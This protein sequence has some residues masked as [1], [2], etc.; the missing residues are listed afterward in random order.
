VER[1]IAGEQV[2]LGD[3][4]LEAVDFEGR[5]GD[6]TIAERTTRGGA[7]RGESAR[8]RD[9]LLKG[10]AEAPGN[11]FDIG[12]PRE[13]VPEPPKRGDGEQPKLRVQAS[14]PPD[15]TPML[16]T[17]DPDGFLSWVLPT[18]HEELA[19]LA[20]ATSRSAGRGTEA[21]VATFE[22][23]MQLP[24]SPQVE[25]PAARGIGSFVFKKV[26]R[27]VSAALFDRFMKQGGEQLARWM[28][29]SRNHALRAFTPDDYRLAMSRSLGESELRAIQHAGT[30]LL[31]IHGTNSLSHSGFHLL[32]PEFVRAMWD[33]YERR[34]L[35]FDHPTLSVDPGH[36]ARRLAELLPAGLDLQLDIVAHSRGGLV[37]RELAQR[38]NANGLDGK[39][40]VQSVTFVGTP[41]LGTPFCNSDHLASYVDAMTNLLSA[42]PD[43]GI[44]D[45]VDCVVGV[46]SHVAR[47]MYAGI[48][49]AMAMDPEGDYLK[50]LNAEPH[51]SDCEYRV[52]TSEFEPI[53]GSGWKRHLRDL[54]VDKVFADKPN[55]LVVPTDPDWEPDRVSERL[56][57]E[58]SSGVDHSTYWKNEQVLDALRGS[59]TVQNAVTPRVV[60]AAPEVRAEPLGAEPAPPASTTPDDAD[61]TT[62]A[63]EV[64]HG[65]LEHARYPVVVGHYRGSPLEGAEGYVDDRVRGVLSRR[66]LLGLYPEDEGQVFEFLGKSTKP[67]GVIVVGLGAPDDMSATKLVR[68]VTHAAL[69]RLVAV[70]DER[71][72][73]TDESE[74]GTDVGLSLVLL[75]TSRPG[76]LPVP[77]CVTAAVEGVQRAN[78][79]VG[80][81]YATSADSAR[82][83][84]LPQITRIE[85]LERD[86]DRAEI[87][88]RTLLKNEVQL[89]GSNVVPAK[90]LRRGEGARAA[91]A[92][93]DERSVAWR[94]LKIERKKSSDDTPASSDGTP[95]TLEY[96]LMGGYAGAPVAEHVVDPALLDPLLA[97]ASTRVD[98][99]EQVQN[100]LFELLFPREVKLALAAGGSFTMLL[101]DAVANYPW[102]MLASRDETPGS[103]RPEPLCVQGGFLRRLETKGDERRRGPGGKAAL[104][105]GNPPV[106]PTAASLPGACSEAVVVANSLLEHEYDV[107][108]LIFDVDG[109]PVVD[110]RPLARNPL[111][112]DGRHEHYWKTIVH[113]LFRREYRILHIAAHGHFDAEH[114][115]RSGALIGPDLFMSSAIVGSLPVIPDF[116][117]FNCCHLGRIDTVP[118]ARIAASVAKT[119]MEHGVRAVVAAGWAVDD[120]DAMTFATTLYDC[121]CGGAP[122]G[123]AV[124]EARRAIYPEDGPKSSTW[125]AY[126][127]YGDPGWRLAQRPERRGDGGDLQFESDAQRALA[128]LATAAG[129]VTTKQER[130]QARTKLAERLE[131]IVD[132]VRK[133]GW[134]SCNVLAALGRAQ[135]KLGELEGAI[136]SYREIVEWSSGGDY[137]VSVIEQ[138]AN[139]EF[140]LAHKRFRTAGVITPEVTKLFE[141]ADARLAALLSLEQT[142]ERLG[143]LGSYHKK[144]ATTLDGQERT[145]EMQMAY[146]AYLKAEEIDAVPY[147]SLNRLQLGALRNIPAPDDAV[148]VDD[149]E[150]R[151]GN[152]TR[153]HL[154]AAE[155]DYWRR[156][157]MVDAHL[158]RAIQNN[159][160][161]DRCAELAE[162]YASVFRERSTWSERDSTISHLWDLAQVHPDPAA[163]TALTALYS[164]LSDDWQGE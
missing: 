138:L 47:K 11:A 90:Q 17:E 87:A 150:I 23:P 35:A 152:P 101:D 76:G 117:F 77:S 163:A 45:A 50:A 82:K 18:N 31:F 153:T 88:A 8:V 54:V 159:E 151:L 65:S 15:R 97:D 80:S 69:A 38:A 94:T 49:G 43:N 10:L 160:V 120:A 123:E 133:N 83:P 131:D 154:T 161:A 39:V 62:I 136:N 125:G 95:M 96:T 26:F 112:A 89:L 135:T 91:R 134:R 41:N 27:V 40:R 142:S 29:R 81:L 7:A 111:D 32:P 110:A 119:L 33:R 68:H 14:V 100:T 16:L 113:E 146:D 44:T 107:T 118:T 147:S 116:V 64:V 149:V 13:V 24:S 158:T 145:T 67:P 122:F 162:E 86:E 20:H 57:L 70:M 103:R 73:G 25:G 51:P 48:P 34:V 114:P 6:A 55:D 75:G 36:N 121:L 9:L 130:R 52:I 126:Q 93:I 164:Q 92:A 108:R 72:S 30:A 4:R 127:C 157:G 78:R 28:E 106:G 155:A 1:L 21:R 42:L 148:S 59:E 37:A 124:R 56:V 109:T 99:D 61:A 60:A 141:R 58:K 144:R 79:H 85:F 104:V 22:I 105:I 71:E 132:E 156:V 98:C 46:L 2:E 140:R 19:E 139:C 129:E 143:L 63:V 74:A 84:P 137:E 12:K 53:D 5:V 102:E 3:V 128:D 115:E 66:Q